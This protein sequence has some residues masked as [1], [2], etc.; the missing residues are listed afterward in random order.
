MTS[1]KTGYDV[2]GDVHGHAD[3][4]IGLLG[5]R[6]YGPAGGVW[7]HADRMAVFVGDL[8]DRGPQQLET[9]DVV[10]PMVAAET[11]AGDP[12]QPRVQRDRL[13]DARPGAPG[14]VPAHP[15]RRG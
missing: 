9:I 13:R 5:E 15:F 7:V 2:I 10:R 11:G 1:T 12:R 4:L 14:G 6:G 3:K 8:I